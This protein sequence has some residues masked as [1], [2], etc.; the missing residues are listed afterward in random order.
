MI[1]NLQRLLYTL[2]IL[3]PIPIVPSIIYIIQNG[4]YTRIVTIVILTSLIIVLYHFWF[5]WYG[6]RNLACIDFTP[7][8]TPEEADIEVIKIL[9]SYFPTLV[10]LVLK[11]TIALW[12][13]FCVA[14]ILL[15]IFMHMNN[16]IPS[17]WYSLLGYH[18]HK[19]KTEGRSY[20]MLSK[21]KNYRSKTT[22][23][24]VK[25]LFDDMLIVENKG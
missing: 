12:G 8:S 25:R 16:T 11:T 24:S 10:Q 23:N 15:I 18:Y 20:M 17:P 13:I 3:A 22:V 9:I 7:D 1:N 2:A 19:I 21:K 6:K 4:S 14:L 5:L